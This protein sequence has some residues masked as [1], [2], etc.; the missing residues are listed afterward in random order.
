MRSALSTQASVL[1]LFLSSCGLRA[2]DVLACYKNLYLDNSLAA[3]LSNPSGTLGVCASR[4]D[5]GAPKAFMSHP[6][7]TDSAV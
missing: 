4:R 1:E 2:S 3:K 7:S 6:L 5:S